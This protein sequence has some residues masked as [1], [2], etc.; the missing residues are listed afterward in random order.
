MTELDKATSKGKRI[1]KKSSKK[2]RE[3]AAMADAL[4]IELHIICQQD[5]K[6][7][8]E[9]AETAKAKEEFPAKEMSRFYRNLLSS[10]AKYAWNKIVKKQMA[11]EPYKDLQGISKKRLRGPLRKSFDDCVIFHLFAMFPNKA[12]EQEKYYLLNVLTKPQHISM[13]QFVQRMEQLNAYVVQLLC[14]YYS[15]SFKPGMTLVNVLFTKADLVSH[16]LRMCP[17]M[18]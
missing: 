5:L 7:A 15:P 10:N 6:K 11:S 8:K 2:A 12:A 13:H 4:D 17:L 1:S 18:W 9:A 3:G 16:L 14:W